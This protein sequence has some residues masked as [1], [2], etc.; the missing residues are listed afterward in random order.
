MYPGDIEFSKSLN[1]N[2][3]SYVLSD[4]CELNATEDRKIISRIISAYGRS[5]KK[6]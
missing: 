6:A 5:L 1:N 2:G 4:F 3:L